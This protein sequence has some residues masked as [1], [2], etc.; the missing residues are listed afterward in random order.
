[1]TSPKDGRSIRAG[2]GG[3][4]RRRTVHGFAASSLALLLVLGAGPS[5][6][7]ALVRDEA[8]AEPPAEPARFGSLG[9][10][11]LLPGW[12]QLAE[13]RYVKG[14]AFLS[15]EVLCLVG[16]LSTNHSANAYYEK[17][18][19]AVTPEDAVRYRALT[20]KYDTWRNRV[21]LA[22][23]AVWVVNLIDI[24]A[25]VK[26]NEKKQGALRLGLE[27]GPGSGLAVTLTYRR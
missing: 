19:S 7:L 18:Q 4:L 16:F 26:D 3:R 22:A 10:S 9:K 2:G 11:L 25:I 8:Q 27:C 20:E 14:I 21:L 24:S 5:A 23:A 15:A 12:G 17:Y 1:M 6:S 13:K